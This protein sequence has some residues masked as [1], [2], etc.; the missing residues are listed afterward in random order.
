ML[1]NIR[2]NIRPWLP[3]AHH[4]A[5]VNVWEQKFLQLRLSCDVICKINKTR[6]Q[7][8]ERIPI[9]LTG[10]SVLWQ[11]PV[12]QHCCNNRPLCGRRFGNNS[13]PVPYCV[14]RLQKD[15]PVPHW[16]RGR[17]RWWQWITASGYGGTEASER[18][19][20]NVTAQCADNAAL[21]DCPGMHATQFLT[22]SDDVGDCKLK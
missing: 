13:C 12:R 11:Q 6:A 21:T 3:V 10:V 15:F 4:Q 18:V 14:N 2:L 16:H 19:P 9:L 17:A 20:A 7:Q 1:N 8:M 5:N 22:S